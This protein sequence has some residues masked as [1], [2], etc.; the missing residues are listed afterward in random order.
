ML[1]VNSFAGCTLETKVHEYQ[2]FGWAR[3][4]Y[5]NGTTSTGGPQAGFVL[6]WLEVAA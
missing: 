3:G 6:L 1:C 5:E 2:I 4:C